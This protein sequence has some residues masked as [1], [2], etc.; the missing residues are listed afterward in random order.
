MTKNE[1]ILFDCI[2]K[3]SEVST[4]SSLI[5][6]EQISIISVLKDD[7][8]IKKGKINK[9][10][11]FLLDGVCRSFLYNPEGEDIT[12]SFFQG[13][14]VLS[15]HTIR[16]SG[17]KSIFHFQAST[18]LVLGCL[19][20]EAFLNLMISNIEI[21]EFGNSVLRNELLQK[22]DKEIGLASLTARQRLIK[23]R[24][25]Y[26]MLENLIAH[27]QIASYLGITA[28]SLSRLRGDISR[29]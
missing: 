5:L 27:T 19:D 1:S 2:H 21:R 13:P 6:S 22:V 15:P 7:I 20:A 10:E 25:Q 16:T 18:D 14:T 9:E 26:G 17:G 24:T 3:I 23:F 12:I 11:Y 8:F 29:E 28:I 4:K